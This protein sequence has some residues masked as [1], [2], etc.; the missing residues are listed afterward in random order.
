M[1][2]YILV[3]SP[4]FCELMSVVIE[5]GGITIW[6][7]VVSRVEMDEVRERHEAIHALQQLEVA[8]LSTVLLAAQV[9]FTGW[10]WLLLW[11]WVPYLGP[12]FIM[13]GASWFIGMAKHR[14]GLE[15]YLDIIF[16]HEAYDNEDDETY[17]DT[18]AWFAWIR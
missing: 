14:N 17:L 9:P 16:E 6:P 4:R 8:V 12:Y 11:P 5:V 10:W 1:K 2:P 3:V 18:R 13:Y 15:A 7:F